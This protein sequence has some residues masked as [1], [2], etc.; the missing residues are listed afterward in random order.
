M[1]NSDA[2]RPDMLRT[3]DAMR[4]SDSQPGRRSVRI[5]LLHLVKMVERSTN[6]QYHDSD[7][8]LDFLL[9]YREFTTPLQ[10]LEILIDR[11]MQGPQAGVSQMIQQASDEEKKIVQIK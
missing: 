5:L 10:L 4:A 2:M 3:S 11:F 6:E 1:R 8:V 7:Y 9:A